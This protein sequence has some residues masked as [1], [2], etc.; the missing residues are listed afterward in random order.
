MS[1]PPVRV[2]WRAPLALALLLLVSGCARP[3]PAAGL[4]PLPLLTTSD[5][6]LREVTSLQPTL[7]WEAFPRPEGL[8]LDKAGTLAR[9]RAPTY[10]LRVWRVDGTYSSLQEKYGLF[11][12]RPGDLVY[13]RTGLAEP[14][15]TIEAAL[16]PETLYL[17]TVRARFELD[18]QPRVTEWAVMTGPRFFRPVEIP[19]IGYYRFK[20]PSS[21]QTGSAP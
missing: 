16:A 20:T 19:D 2:D 11:E 12:F 9:V 10:E 21:K 14:V 8:A 13:A 5:R 18:G 15:H 7:R 4:R 3:I 6:P 1:H 17:W